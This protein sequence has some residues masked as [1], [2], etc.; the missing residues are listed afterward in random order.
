MANSQA[1]TIKANPAQKQFRDFI[2]CDSVMKSIAE[3]IPK[4]MDAERFARV[5]LSATGQTPKLLECNIDTIF[6]SV[7]R[8]AAMGLEPDGGPLG[9]GYLVPFYSGKNKRYECQFIPGYRGLIKLARNSGEVADVWAEVVYKADRFDY[10]LG[11]NPTLSH[12]PDDDID[13]PGPLRFAYA[14]CRFRDGERKFVRMNRRE[15]EKVKASSSSRYKP[16]DK[17]KKAGEQGTL[18]GPWVDWEEEMWKKTAVR[19]LAKML[20]LAV[21]RSYE[22][23]SED[24]THRAALDA[25]GVAL[26]EVEMP[27][28]GPT[29]E[30]PSDLPGDTPRDEGNGRGSEPPSDVPPAQRAAHALS[31]FANCGT[32]TEVDV[33]LQAILDSTPDNSQTWETQ[34]AQMAD[35]AKQKIRDKRNSRSKPPNQG[36]ATQGDLLD[37][38]ADAAADV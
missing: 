27:K 36:A 30:P 11:L 10:E 19:R 18:V 3:T 21:E 8:A 1:L 9:Q 22:I 26:P 4:H 38:D 6:L 25:M 29:T 5:V 33:A 34:L 31:S 15:I 14:V 16:T 12:K 37:V 32:L 23:A 17:Q 20:P 13:D 24:M 7:L 28:I 2:T 35:A